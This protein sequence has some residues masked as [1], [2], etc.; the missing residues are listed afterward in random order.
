MFLAFRSIS[1]LNITMHVIRYFTK[2]AL[3]GPWSEERMAVVLIR[4]K[5]G[6]G[7]TQMQFTWHEAPSPEPLQLAALRPLTERTQSDAMRSMQYCF[8]DIGLPVHP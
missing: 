5:L 7:I 8:H 1:L 4:G 2:L 6:C 3:F